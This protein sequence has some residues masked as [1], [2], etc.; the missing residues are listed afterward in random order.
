MSADG[1]I[2]TQVPKPA[3]T[4]IVSPATSAVMREMTRTALR[5]SSAVS[6]LVR[7]GY[8]VGGKTGTSQTIDPATGKYTEDNTIGSYLGYGGDDKPRYVI[9]VRVDDSHIGA[10]NFAGS[11]AA[12]PIFGELS[13]WL[14]DYYNI[15]PL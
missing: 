9:M 1:N 7:P 4:G 6:S 11:A 2:N 8:N 10:A 12:G 13:N 3:R 14:I 15:K 5:E